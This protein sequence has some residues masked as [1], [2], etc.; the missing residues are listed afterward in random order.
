MTVVSRLSVPAQG[1]PEPVPVPVL[2]PDPELVYAEHLPTG[3]VFELCEWC[4][5]VIRE[6]G[7]AWQQGAG[8]FP[9]GL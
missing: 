1:V 3:E 4:G 2:V 5:L 6:T 8:G 7:T 9:V